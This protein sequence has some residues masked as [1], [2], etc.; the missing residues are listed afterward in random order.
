MPFERLRSLQIDLYSLCRISG[1]DE[2]TCAIVFSHLSFF[3]RG[4]LSLQ[5]F[6][7]TDW[8]PLTLW[9]W[10]YPSLGKYTEHNREGPNRL[11]E[12]TMMLV[13]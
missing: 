4:L 12:I 3:P 9:Y 6:E 2:D 10:D 1:L 8:Y 11:G 5:V 13:L 7:T